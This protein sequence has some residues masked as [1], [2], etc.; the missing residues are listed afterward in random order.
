M[1]DM[2][3]RE[4]NLPSK[5]RLRNINVGWLKMIQCLKELLEK[6]DIIN[7]K[8]GDLFLQLVDLTKELRIPHLIM[9]SILLSKDQLQEHLDTLKVAWEN[10]FNEIIEYS[11]EEVE[12]WLIHYVNKNDEV[13]DMLHQLN[14]DIRDIEK[15]L[16]DAKIKHETMVSPM[17][18]YI[19]VWLKKALIKIIEPDQPKL[20]TTA[21]EPL[22]KD[23]TKSTPTSK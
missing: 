9:D 13:E 19:K 12:K 11:E 5:I 4:K 6:C 18:E 2:Q 15:E 22:A 1:N 21:M 14:F 23:S 7:G 20:V 10:E 3:R 17:Q 8:R 16:F